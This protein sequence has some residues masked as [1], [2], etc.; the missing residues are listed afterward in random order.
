M[1]RIIFFLI[2]VL[3]I[4]GIADS[5][6]LTYEHYSNF[7]PPCSATF[8]FIDCGKVL[9]SRYSL[10]FG[11]PLA[12]IG[13]VHYSLLSLSVFLSLIFYKKIFRYLAVYFSWEGLLASL[14]FMFLQIVVLRSICLY[15]TLSALISFI[16]FCLA[17]WSLRENQKELIVY[18]FGF[19]YRKIIKNIFF[20]F[21][22]ETI[23]E[24]LTSTGEFLGDCSFSKAI[25]N[26]FI[27][28]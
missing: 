13:I 16:I 12:L 18:F 9:K 25:T 8:S 26:Y 3:G 11:I 10:V 2:L 27:K 24:L 5:A 20:L 21:N 14:Y 19:L 23:H 22:P 6:Y 15:C 1:K 7:I 4:L 28:S 17:Q